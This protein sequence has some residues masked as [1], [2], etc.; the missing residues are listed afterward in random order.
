MVLVLTDAYEDKLNLIVSQSSSQ[1]S[2]PHGKFYCSSQA[3]CLKGIKSNCIPEFLSRPLLPMENSDV[4]LKPN[5]AQ[6]SEREKKKRKK[7]PKNTS[8]EFYL[9]M[10]HSGFDGIC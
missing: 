6:H 1:T 3:K 10:L 7:L 8:F 5:A 9:F 2:P 4:L